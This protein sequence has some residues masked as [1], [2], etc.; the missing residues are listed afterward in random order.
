MLYEIV[1]TYLD[2]DKKKQLVRIVEDIRYWGL[3]KDEA[4]SSSREKLEDIANRLSS[5]LTNEQKYI[6]R[7][8]PLFYY[9]SDT[10]L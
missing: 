9:L 8:V 3:R 2:S 7:P 10:L 4:I 5:Y 1:F 6:V